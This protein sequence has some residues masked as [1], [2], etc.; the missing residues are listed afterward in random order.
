MSAVKRYNHFY[1]SVVGNIG[2]DLLTRVIHGARGIR[3]RAAGK[4]KPLADQSTGPRRATFRT[5]SIA[6]GE[7]RRRNI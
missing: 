1:S 7:E 4:N 3:D 5:L 2:I 6:V